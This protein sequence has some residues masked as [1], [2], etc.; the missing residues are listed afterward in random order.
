MEVTNLYACV[1]NDAVK[2]KWYVGERGD[3]MVGVRSIGCA[4]GDGW[5]G[6]V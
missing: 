3:G 5:D 2:G 4:C 1:V 6:L